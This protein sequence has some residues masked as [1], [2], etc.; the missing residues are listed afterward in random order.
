MAGTARLLSVALVSLGILTLTSGAASAGPPPCPDYEILASAPGQSCASLSSWHPLLNDDLDED[1]AAPDMHCVDVFPGHPLSSVLEKWRV[2][3]FVPG[4]DTG[5]AWSWIS[6][7]KSYGFKGDPMCTASLGEGD[8]EATEAVELDLIASVE[9][10]QRKH[11]MEALDVRGSAV[12]PRQ[13]VRVRVVDNAHVHGPSIVHII[14][15]IESVMLKARALDVQLLDVF[16]GKDSASMADVAS[17]IWSDFETHFANRPTLYNLSMV[18]PMSHV[19]ALLTDLYRD[20][21]HAMTMPS[22]HVPH[23]ASK[24][25]SYKNIELPVFV[26]AAGANAPVSENFFA[27]LS[28]LYVGPEASLYK[29]V[30]ILSE[31]DV[32]S[33]RNANTAFTVLGAVGTRYGHAKI[34]EAMGSSFSTAYVT[35]AMAV[36]AAVQSASPAFRWQNDAWN[37]LYDTGITALNAWGGPLGKEIASARD[38]GKAHVRRI[39]IRRAIE[40][41][42]GWAVKPAVWPA[43][44]SGSAFAYNDAYTTIAIESALA[45]GHTKYATTEWCWHVIDPWTWGI[46]DFDKTPPHNDNC[47]TAAPAVNTDKSA[48]DEPWGN[49]TP[50]GNDCPNCSVT[51]MHGS[52]EIYF[53]VYNASGGVMSLTG[54]TLTD[55]VGVP[56]TFAVSDTFAPNSRGLVYITGSRAGGWG[57]TDTASMEYVTGSTYK[58]QTIGHRDM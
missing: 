4:V 54:V 55:G 46:V 11:I 39:A 37:P 38:G 12:W 58:V 35:A 26:L 10:D 19:T 36:V 21:G 48:L 23:L 1:G 32:R 5:K 3:R 28:T 52:N 45:A 14:E 56:H 25:K 33:P 18:Y 8:T 24:A 6:D 53:S 22:V 41:V 29:A 49:P 42:R 34:P 30:G 20:L 40:A 13:D 47:G 51:V 15:D 16:K 17:G 57:V 31:Y 27:S 50:N 7:F 9:V 44:G 43:A 2:I